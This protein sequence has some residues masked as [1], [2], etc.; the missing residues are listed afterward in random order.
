MTSSDTVVQMQCV[1]RIFL[2]VFLTLEIIQGVS[3]DS[4]VAWRNLG[5]ERSFRPHDLAQHRRLSALKTEYMEL[6]LKINSTCI[7]LWRQGELLYERHGDAVTA[8]S[9]SG[10][11]TG[12]HVIVLHESLGHVMSARQYFTCQPSEHVR[13]ARGLAAVGAGRALVVAGVPEWIMF[14]GKAAV[15]ALGSLGSSWASRLVHGE[16]W[17]WV[18]VKGVGTVAE[19]ASV[20]QDL[21]YPSHELLVDAHVAKTPPR[22]RCEWYKRPDLKRQMTFCERYDGYG[23]LCS[24]DDPFFPEVRK[25]QGAIPTRETIPVVVATANKP[26]H[27]FR[28]IR[29]LFTVAGSWQTPVLIV[30]D[31]AH[32]ET[33]ALA[34]VLQTEII[35]HAPES[36]GN[37]RA[38]ANIR[39]ALHAVFA[40]FPRADK[41]I[42]L[43]DDLLLSPDILR[44][45]HQVSPILDI[46]PTV[47]CVN[48]FS[49]N[50]YRDTASDP[51]QLLRAR[52]YP[53]Y[54][55]M[56]TRAYAEEIVRKWVPPGVGDWDF[57]LAWED[58][59]Q[60]RDVVF[61][62]VS[63]TFHAGSAGVH[64]TGFE[65]ESVFNRMIFNQD[66]EVDLED[67]HQVVRDRYDERLTFDLQRALQPTPPRNVC[68]MTW[69]PRHSPVPVSLYV[70]AEDSNDKHWSFRIFLSC[71]LTYD[72]NTHEIYKGVI[73]LRWH[74]TLVY[75]VGC[76]ISPFCRYLRAGQL[77]KPTPG[78]LKRAGSYRDDWEQNF[79][80]ENS[81]LYRTKDAPLDEVFNLTNIIRKEG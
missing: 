50:S 37:E 72:E 79:F 36:A 9:Q 33:L 60:G 47:Y 62:E 30:V 21:A 14:L 1:M 18:G 31:G 13:L 45:F 19:A 65:Q 67:I 12:V 52:T 11:Q 59:R 38:N 5:R 26:Y 4:M 22:R 7:Q 69:L 43:E 54:G 32:E 75:L 48:A 44:Y 71:F 77:T 66:P 63:R 35:I 15:D 28:L 6:S 81:G 78:D 55:W 8:E 27:L 57:W 16:A 20:R 42:L 56:V 49:S 76:P 24:C 64:V 29:Q 74:G 3:A 2:V 25:L 51:R 68:N 58:Q 80:E 17:A 34:E 10:Q 61:P 41:A 53:M 46:D 70:F 40:R 39:F 73:R 23:D